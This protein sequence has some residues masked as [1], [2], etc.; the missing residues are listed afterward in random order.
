MPFSLLLLLLLFTPEGLRG[1]TQGKGEGADRALPQLSG[2]G[3]MGSSLSVSRYPTTKS[4]CTAGI[5]IAPTTTIF[6]CSPSLL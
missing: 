3:T 6:I 1:H 5:P 4:T 2:L